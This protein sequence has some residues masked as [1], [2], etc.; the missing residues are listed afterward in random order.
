MS[1]SIRD[2]VAVELRTGASQREVA[3]PMPR[4]GVYRSGCYYVLCEGGDSTQSP[5]NNTMYAVRLPVWRAVTLNL[6]GVEVITAGESG[7]TVRLGIYSDET[8]QGCY[9]GALLLDAGTAAADSTGRK[10]ITISQRLPVG[11]YWAVV[12]VQ[13]NSG[14]PATEIKM[15]SGYTPGAAGLYSDLVN[16]FSGGFKENTQATTGALPATFP[17]TENSTRQ[18]K[19]YV[20]AA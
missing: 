5:L 1:V 20:R 18:P 11:L 7:A 17:A 19:I 3:I 4:E 13:N 6:I 9:P 14:T 16:T 15:T 10:D 2:G 8:I 12:C